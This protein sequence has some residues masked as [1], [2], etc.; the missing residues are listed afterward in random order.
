MHVDRQT[1]LALAFGMAGVACNQGPPAQGAASVVE[2]PRQPIPPAD[3]G[4]APVVVPPPKPVAA[5]TDEEDD[6]DVGLPTDEDGASSVA[7]ADGCGFVA[8]ASVKRPTGACND[9]T[10]SAPACSMMSACGGFAFP[11]QRCEE[12]RTMFKP[13][14]ARRALACLA[15]LS[16]KK[17]CDACS[18]YRCGDLA[19]KTSCP[20]PTAAPLC[21][22]V[23]SSCKSVT[24]A[25]CELYMSGLSA[26]GRAKL[27]SCLTST[28]G[29]RFGIYS[30]AES[31]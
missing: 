16:S 20:D 1:F 3:A 29:C 27:A 24:Q 5:P 9:G 11:K 26:T 31:L 30:C 19:L 13:G 18:A 25:S 8:P 23:R 21:T 12:Y 28:S 15:G 4:V 6:D 7:S 10:G 22:K 14:T 17:R 2:I